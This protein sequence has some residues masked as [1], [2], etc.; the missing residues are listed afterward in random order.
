MTMATKK[1]PLVPPLPNPTSSLTNQALAQ[2]NRNLVKALSQ[3]LS[4]MA[5]LVNSAVQG[6][7]IEPDSVY[8][9]YVLDRA[10]HTGTQSADTI[11]DGVANKVFTAA[12]KTKLSTV[13]QRANHTGTQ[14][15]STVTR[16]T[17]GPRIGL[18]TWNLAQ[19]N[20]GYITP[21][22]FGSTGSGVHNSTEN[23]RILDAIDVSVDLGINKVLWDGNFDSDY[24]ELNDAVTFTGRSVQDSLTVHCDN[25]VPGIHYRAIGKVLWSNFD[26]RV[27]AAT[28]ITNGTGH[29]GTAI[30]MGDFFPGDDNEPVHSTGLSL[31]HM[32]I[33]RVA[34]TEV[35]HAL[36][37]AGGS[38]GMHVFD[39]D[40]VG[41][42]DAFH[43]DAILL[44]WSGQS[45]GVSTASILVDGVVTPFSPGEL[46]V[47]GTSGASGI[48]TKYEAP[49]A[50]YGRIGMKEIVGTFQDN[51]TLSAIGGGLAT[52]RGRTYVY[53]I[54]YDAGAGT[55][56]VGSTITG[57][58]NG[59]STVA[60]HEAITA[61]TGTLYLWN[62]ASVRDYD[63]NETFTGSAGGSGT[64]NGTRVSSGLVQGQFQPG[65]NSWHPHD[66]SMRSCR[67]TNVQRIAALS[68]A[69][70][71]VFEDIRGDDELVQ[72]FDTPVGD[73]ANTFAT[74]EE[75][76]QVYKGYSFENVHAP[77][78]LGSG[79]NAVTVFDVSGLSTSK[80]T[81]ADL[82]FYAD[83][84]YAGE[85]Y[86]GAQDRSRSI[87]FKNHRVKNVSWEAG[88]G[89]GTTPYEQQLWYRNATGDFMVESM[90]ADGRDEVL[91][92]K[93]DN[94]RGKMTV[95]DSTMLGGVY[96]NRADGVLLKNNIIE[97]NDP[98]LNVLD[99]LGDVTTYTTDATGF[100]EA[101][102]SFTLSA[103][104]SSRFLVGTPV[105]YSAGTT[106]VSKIVNTDDTVVYV[107][108]I[109]E[110]ATGVQSFQF[111]TSSHVVLRDNTFAKGKRGIYAREE[112]YVSMADNVIEKNTDVG[113]LVGDKA[114][115]HNRGSIFQGNG[116]ENYITPST[117]TRDVQIGSGGLAY[118][119]QA[120][121]RDSKGVDY[122]VLVSAGAKGG[123]LT[124]SIF[125][126]DPVISHYLSAAGEP[127]KFENNLDVNGDEVLPAAV[128]KAEMKFAPKL[129]VA[130]DSRGDQVSDTGRRAWRGWMTP[131]IMLTNGRIDFANS[132]N[133]AVAGDDSSDFLA[134]VT[135]LLSVEPGI[136]VAIISTNDRTAGWTAQQSI[137][138]MA[139]W[140]RLILS[141]GHKI[142]WISETPRGSAEDGTYTLSATNLRHH[143]RV[144]AWQL[145]QA[146]VPGVYVVDPWVVLGDATSTTGL[147][148]N[149]L[150]YDGLHF[151]PPASVLVAGL[152]ANVINELL[153]YRPRLI[154]ANSN[155]WNANNETGALNANP[156]LDGTGGT[157]GTNSSG[158]VATSWTTVGGAGMTAVNSKVTVDG[159]PRQRIVVTGTPTTADSGAS[160]VDPTPYSVVCSVPLTGT[161]NVGDVI[162]GSAYVSIAAGASGLRGVSVYLT[163]TTASGTT[164][165][166]SG[167]PHPANSVIN[168]DLPATALEG[169]HFTEKATIT[170]A[171]TSATL[172]I[173]ITGR[174]NNTSAISTTVEFTKAAA[175]KILD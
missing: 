165:Y 16:S 55:F 83:A 87:V 41:A 162:Q 61:T 93:V 175:R 137:D 51:E 129:Y 14:D 139:E 152:I 89:G 42:A 77:L 6:N 76:D 118:T 113:L 173:V 174:P 72:F 161:I 43:G 164:T 95:K 2:F 99:V 98:D 54:E 7:I 10:N 106:Y 38:Y 151:G 49:C 167:E 126:D 163:I 40:F 143:L 136:V 149:G 134:A 15:E 82:A 73:E 67:M 130:G 27:A 117:G 53:K 35:G 123:S 172:S 70:R 85:T 138:N 101:A 88:T 46:V 145:A 78:T 32:Q 45:P 132:Q 58:T 4:E 47:G 154:E 155:L 103:A 157:N 86:Y 97:Q 133:Y 64:F 63:N 25:T 84:S 160:P 119:D 24:F 146:Q 81:D 31:A 159:Y 71:V 125:E 39:T 171:V 127:F 108:P 69:Y 114:V 59:T 107:E 158:S 131:L 104:T 109:P 44:H 56:P 156:M 9:A 29:N 170:E 96:I 37:L 48:V 65:N 20:N 5:R 148:I 21:R 8:T 80:Q 23:D 30:T 91:S 168:L 28:G 92:L 26:L 17:T 22:D 105:R 13:E 121:F 66:F 116:T 33:S 102:T 19:R 144:R 90:D 141:H 62:G 11:T 153:P 112:A 74:A 100:V 111:D 75:K 1:I 166:A 115:V 18:F 142:I 94:F 68:G 12:E 147:A 57:V 128:R 150:M 34:G 79:A 120:L 60:N 135:P 50:T 122:H 3:Y 36:V 110:A 140:Q 169:T 124:N 52:A